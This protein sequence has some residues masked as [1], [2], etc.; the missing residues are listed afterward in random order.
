MLKLLKFYHQKKKKRDMHYYY[1]WL[2]HPSLDS[3]LI[4]QG[5]EASLSDVGLSKFMREGRRSILAYP[6]A[7]NTWLEAE[8]K[9]L[10]IRQWWEVSFPDVGLSKFVWEGRKSIVAY[11]K[12]NNTWLGAETKVLLQKG[13]SH[14]CLMGTL[15]LR[16][17]AY[18]TRVGGVS[19]Q[20]GIEQIRAGG[21]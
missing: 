8:M 10:L 17:K 20:C 21:T 15:F 2:V 6:R 18:K 9:V 7:N 11:P 13:A 19:P 12:A 3:M 4:R 1:T 16:P 14:P 5:W